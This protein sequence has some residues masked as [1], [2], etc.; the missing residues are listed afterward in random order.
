YLELSEQIRMVPVAHGVQA[1]AD[2][3]RRAV[4]LYQPTCVAVELPRMLREELLEL[5]GYL[6]EIRLLCYRLPGATAYMI[7]GDPCDSLIEATRLALDH[8][9]ALEFV[10]TIHAGGQDE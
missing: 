6:P 2:E 8:G 4:H 9:L 3:V 10:D 1:Y 7:P 5:V